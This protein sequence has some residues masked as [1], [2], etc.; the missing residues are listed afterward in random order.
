M[1]IG[2]ISE[3]AMTAHI[4]QQVVSSTPAHRVVW[5]AD[6]VDDAV[7]RCATERPD[8][9]LMDLL[10]TGADCLDVVRRI[11]AT[12]PCPILM[13][14]DSVNGNAA[15]VFDA[16]G[17]GA[18][19][20]VDM[21]VMGSAGPHVVTPL[22]TKINTI[23]RLVGA[24]DRIA[25]RCAAST[26][27]PSRREGH[28]LLIAIGASA[29][30]PA[31]LV[32]LLSELPAVFPGAI[33][34]VQHVDEA[35]AAGMTE[36]LGRHTSMPVRL[37]V[38]GDRPMPGTILL[39]GTSD[40]LVLK[41]PNQLGYTPEPRHLVYRPSVDIF[42]Q[43]VAHLWAGDAVGVLLTGMGRDGALGLKALRDGGHHTIAQDEASSAVYGMPKAAV[44]I[45]A[46][47]EILPLGRIATRLIAYCSEN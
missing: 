5:I 36:W 34:I 18:L 14:T 16:M 28:G 45:G 35:F 6:A 33:A 15:R 8:L 32:T 2:I 23:A 24:S 13:V 26:G 31:A 39:A 46:A 3:R 7:E 4:L 22:L 30:G 44:S 11:M 19:D 9:V 1:N 41:R 25:G 20:A 17:C 47:V 42:L 29:G 40:H 10:K 38:E 37:A 12:S 21:P 27:F 43:S